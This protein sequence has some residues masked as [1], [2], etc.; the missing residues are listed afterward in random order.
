[1][2]AGVERIAIAT[3]APFGSGG[4]QLL[5]ELDRVELMVHAEIL[6]MRAANQFTNDQFRGLYVAD[7]Q[8]DA[9]RQA[10]LCGELTGKSERTH[11][12]LELLDRL[13]GECERQLRERCAA[14]NRAGVT[15]PL[16]DLTKL[17][18]L[19]PRERDALLVAVAPEIEPGFETLYSYAQN[20]VTRKR[21]TVG[22]VLR[23][24]GPSAIDRIA[25][26]DV[27]SPA[28]P[29]LSASLLRFLEDGAE[30][31]SALPSRMLR[32]DERV[33]DF[34]LGGDGIDTRLRAFTTCT[35]PGRDLARLH[36]PQEFAVRLRQ[37]SDAL[38]GQ[39]GVVFLHGPPGAGKSA[40]AEALSTEAH[41]PLVVANIRQANA[42]GA[43][44]APT[45]AL[46]RREAR[47]RRAN[48]LL[49]HLESWLSE[50]PGQGQRTEL[51]CDV[52]G[53]FVEGFS[54]RDSS[55]DQSRHILF[56]ASEAPWPA[57]RPVPP[58]ITFE[59]P[60]PDFVCRSR[61]WCEAMP[62]V[63]AGER[64]QLASR[65]ANQFVL[66]GGQI[67]SACQMARTEAQVKG[68][69]PGSLTVADFEAAARALSNQG[70]RRRARKV[71][72]R[73]GWED[74][75]LPKRTLQQLRE[76]CAA[77][78]YRSFIFS[79]WG[80]D[81]RQAQ[82]K[83]L[84]ILF[85]GPSGTGKTMSAGIVA[86]ELGLDLY[87]ID[88]SSVIS[89]YIGETE[90]HLSEIFHEAQSSNAILFFDEADAI[91]GKRSEVKDAHDRYANVEVAYLLQKMEEYEGVVI[92]ATNFRKNVD[93][94]FTRR[95]Q[96][97]VEFPFPEPR[98]RERI[99]RCLIPHGAPLAK[100]VDFGFLARQF[101]MAG[102][103]IRNAA[104]VAAFI[105]AEEG[106]ELRMEHFV[107]ATARELQ[108]MGKLP[109][110]S[111]FKE[112]Y[113]LTRERI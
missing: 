47:L 87:K 84:N 72:A 90:K 49:T 59:F 55:G 93:D 113:D 102:G 14:S 15:L 31:D 33:V 1:M 30:R 74:L 4:E 12:A 62:S 79:E 65:L 94:A 52:L 9:L 34:L 60:I 16:E 10:A 2:P 19:S 95:I 38:A 66:T 26:R 40:V 100:D 54:N 32:P 56:I 43:A 82:G 41:R 109:T 75:V 8:I 58:W 42:A 29:L 88:L 45:L 17:Y 37:A 7:E 44:A 99:W 96:Y 20:D 51:N 68:R 28:G 106:G 46:L 35:R 53:E 107:L 50:D 13:L 76:V 61:L 105:A 98:Y 71:E 36:F 78:K 3:A 85:C 103:N 69:D 101:E 73:F 25:L 6:R 48:L 108:K 23:L 81:R 83:G 110:R 63:D 80:F 39:G 24:L 64:Q 21:P 92:L 11:P 77:E 91:F 70:L 22:L 18:S 97:I 5:A 104:L 67:Q 89:K 57:A 27:F 111:D 86:R 112:Y